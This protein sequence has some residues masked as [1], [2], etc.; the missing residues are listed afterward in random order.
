MKK[1]RT[2]W[3]IGMVAAWTNAATVT[4]NFNT[5]LDDSTS[6][7]ALTAGTLSYLVGTQSDGAPDSSQRAWDQTS[8]SGNY[9]LNL[10][11]RGLG[12]SGVSDADLT[13]TGAAT[14]QFTL[15][16]NSGDALDFSA[17]TLNFDA[18]LY[19]DGIS[20]TVGYKVWANTGSVFVALAPRQTAVSTART[21]ET[22][23]R[24]LQTNETTDL[25]GF[26][27]TSGTI[28]GTETALSF[29]VSELEILATNQ[30]ITFAI[31]VSA[32]HNN[33]F[34][35]GNG[36][37]NITLTVAGGTSGPKPPVA[38][39]D[40]Y[41][42]DV[43]A[44]FTNAVP[45]VLENDTDANGDTLTAHVVTFPSSG[46][47]LEF[48]AD[49]SFI[50]QP[51]PAFTGADTFTYETVDA[52]GLTSNVA[53]V[54]LTVGYD[55]SVA[56]IFSD[57]MILQR[58]L[59][60]PVYGKG[61]PGE[62][63]E[64]SFGS[65]TNSAT[66]DASGDW[67]VW[68]APMAANTNPATLTIAGSRDTFTYTNL[69]VGD[70]WVCSG[71]SNMDRSLDKNNPHVENWEA[72]IAAANYPDIRLMN[73]P[74]TYSTNQLVDLPAPAIW[75]VCSSN[76]VNSFSGAGYFFGRK[77]NLETGVPV[78]L[79]ESAVGGT[80]IERWMPEDLRTEIGYTYNDRITQLYNGMIH[81]L[82]GF[83]IKGAIWYQ[84][85]S[86]GY[87]AND[88]LALY[89]DKLE[90]MILGWR[91]AWGVGEFPFY[92]AQ[93]CPH[94]RNEKLKLPIL[95][96]AFTRTLSVPNTGVIS[97]NDLN[98]YTNGEVDIGE[99]HPSNKQDVGLRFGLIALEKTYGG[100]TNTAYTGPLFDSV[101]ATS[102]SVRVHFDPDTLG[103]G[104]AARNAQPLTLFELAGADEIYF[105][106]A[107]ATINGDTVLVSHVSVT[108]PAFIRFGYNGNIP[109]NFMN[110]EGFPVNT[111][112]S[113]VT[114]QSPPVA[115]PDLFNVSVGG[116]GEL[117]VLANDT[118]VENNSL[119]A[120]VVS[121]AQH[122]TLI[123]TNGIFS[124]TPDNGFQGTD[125]FTYVANDGTDDSQVV[126]VSIAVVE[127]TYPNIILPSM[128]GSNRVLQRN[129][130]IPV[131]GWGPAGQI[132]SVSLSSG[133]STSTVV[134]VDGTWETILPSMAATNGPLSMI[135]STVG[136]SVT[137]TNLAVGDVWLCSGQSNMGWRLQFTDGGPEE[138]ALAN[139]PMLRHFYTSKHPTNTPMNN[140]VSENDPARPTAEW[141]VCTPDVAGGYSAISYY[142][143]RDLQLELDIPIGI[144]QS[145]YAGTAV[146]AWT[147][148]VLPNA[149]P[150]ESIVIPAHELFN[151]MIHPWLK[152]PISGFAWRQGDGNRRDG[153][154]YAEKVK[155]MV[156]EW[157]SLWGLGDL[158]LYYA[159][160][161]TVFEQ[162]PDPT[163]PLFWEGQTEIMNVLTNSKMIIISDLSDGSN[164]HPK[165]KAPT[166]TRLADRALHNTYGLTN[167]FESYPM[168]NSTTVEGSQIRVHF[169]GTGSGLAMGTN[170]ASVTWFEICGTDGIFTNATATIDGHT[171]L[172]SSPSVSDPIGIRYLWSQYAIGNLFNLEGLPANSFRFHPPLAHGDSYV[173]HMDGELYV[174]PAGILAN[175]ESG[176][177]RLSLQFPIL[178]DTVA[179]GTLMLREDGA[180]I[181]EPNTGFTGT[182]QF[183]YAVT[184][185]METSP[186]AIV[187]IEVFP[188][189]AAT[190]QINRDVWTG[191]SGFLISDL[192]SSTNYPDSPNESGFLPSLDAPQNWGNDYG[193]RIYGYLHPPINGNYTFFISSSARSEFWLSTDDNPANAVKI[194]SS[195]DRAP[196]DWTAAALP[197]SL[198][199]GQRYFIEV[200]HKENSGADHVQVAWDLAEQ[201]TTNIV[202]GTY[203][204][205]IPTEV[206]TTTNYADWSS[207]YGVSGN[208]Y[209]LDF[210][211]NLDPTLN[212]S[213][214]MVPTSGTMG[215]PYWEVQEIDGLSVEYLRRKDASGT[216]YS[217]QFSDNLTSNWMNSTATE[218]VS[219]INGTWERVTVEDELNT[220]TS[221]NRF[222]RVTVIQN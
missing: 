131:W 162:E 161:P 204:S 194:A 15:T 183:S 24:L 48:L 95:W 130:P 92:F 127:P 61:N 9:L 102:T 188:A 220:A 16:P 168:F 90:S 50:Y 203:L 151:G 179:S 145:A 154:N 25:P 177:S 117:N 192:T 4:Y 81:P 97:L 93:I 17:S 112:A 54:T 69:L 86:N 186:E 178:G 88:Q 152:M 1:L 32:K 170:G 43:D 60:V 174:E 40:A 114:T 166:G 108:T 165:N 210:A 190:G 29:D 197:V 142:F 115:H 41:E 80:R 146:E 193:Q 46:T 79:I 58:E 119:S 82:I 87:D 200:L 120:T 134:N 19:T 96:D 39:D 181:Y 133:Q 221:T 217:V 207:W 184:D 199:G 125:R 76:T 171:V 105:T 201:G 110:V 157:R 21:S 2:I 89:K 35:F 22:E 26:E 66:T 219:E 70:I 7:G 214:I 72:E 53:T 129:Q 175:D 111:F 38:N 30:T 159:Q 126:M 47:L 135:V 68:L 5:G 113:A 85:E 212:S 185:G 136:S 147:Q 91:D 124:Y 218:F 52:G 45:G 140:I 213:Q 118:D 160:N 144:I 189:G 109:H 148:S 208:G 215:L 84:G 78:G 63:I 65:Q 37:D 71:Q 83:P 138:M 23:G 163:L 74:R 198:V 173:L 202:D 167:I 139:H 75:K 64:V 107:T 116:T 55:M 33:Q 101:V 6:G 143:G 98:N 195:L 3:A 67:N 158:P 169:D 104:L 172:V 176:S 11:Q 156:E 62:M 123:A 42:I 180:F 8:A 49:G 27:L 132:I 20:S 99:V 137:L 51:T 187:D 28:L 34:N 206:P 106:N 103:S 211:F 100:V 94:N 128:L 150:D 14:L 222:G 57:N 59:D 153:I 191:I 121:N 155:I 77:I 205:G 182:D 122:G 209:T 44:I 216:T 36:I 13:T 164:V 12:N 149:Q 141:T 10:G 31:A 56:N 18:L 196:G 73:V